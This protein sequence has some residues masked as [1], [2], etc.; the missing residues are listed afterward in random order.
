[1]KTFWF[2][3]WILIGLCFASCAKK[4]PPVILQGRNLDSLRVRPFAD[5]LLAFS[6]EL[7]RR[8]RDFDDRFDRIMDRL[9]NA[10]DWQN[11]L[12][13]EIQKP[14]FAVVEKHNLAYLDSLMMLL[15][16]VPDSLRE[17]M[18]V[19]KTGLEAFRD[20]YEQLHQCALMPAMHGIYDRKYRND[21][22]IQ[23]AM[24]SVV[25]YFDTR[26]K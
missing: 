2:F 6:I 10:D 18:R 8:S 11:R 5:R 22:I 12:L 19:Q 24:M 3:G 20:N 16:G 25:A 7:G 1:M 21:L 23:A 14:E 4:E 9:Q 13:L 15:E 17:L 26:K